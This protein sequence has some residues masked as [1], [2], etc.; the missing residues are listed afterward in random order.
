M[1]RNWT[2]IA[3]ILFFAFV[4]VCLGLIIAFTGLSVV[5]FVRMFF[6]EQYERF[7]APS[8]G[9]FCDHQPTM[10]SEPTSHKVRSWER[11]E[12]LRL[13]AEAGEELWHPDDEK[14]RCDWPEHL[15]MKNEVNRL[16]GLSRGLTN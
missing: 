4:G 16:F 6:Y 9:F 11:L 14:Q 7:P 5:E 13:R 12:V 3:D 2:D 8:Y 10:P 15:A 1:K